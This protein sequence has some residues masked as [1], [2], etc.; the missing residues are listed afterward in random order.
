MNTTEI[1]TIAGTR[2]KS[3]DVGDVLMA[4]DD[5]DEYLTDC[6]LHRDAFTN[7]IKQE[8]RAHREKFEFLREESKHES[9]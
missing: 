7:R 8:R 3:D 5:E 6:I 2:L 9:N 1:I 4:D